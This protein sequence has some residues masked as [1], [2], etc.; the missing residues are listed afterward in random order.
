MKTRLS[1][2]LLGSVLM[3][4]TSLTSP[5]LAVPVA[6][7]AQPLAPE[8]VFADPDLSGPKAVG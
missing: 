2:I 4:T 3:A 7:N 1:L 8:R 5:C 6:A